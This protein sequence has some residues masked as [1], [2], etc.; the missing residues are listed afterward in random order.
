MTPITQVFEEK[1]DTVESEAT[2]KKKDK[3]RLVTSDVEKE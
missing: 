2:T 1:Q 3:E